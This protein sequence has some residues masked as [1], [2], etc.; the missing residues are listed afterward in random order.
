MV[1]EAIIIETTKVNDYLH[2]IDLKAYGIPRQLSVYL[3]EFNNA[4]ILFDCGSSLDSKKI[5]RY[6]NKKRIPL[7]SFKYLITSHHHFDHNGGQF[8][9][10][11]E[12]K[13]HNPNVKI[14]TNS[15]TKEL[16][17]N[18]ND[19]LNRAKRTYGNLTGTMKQ[20]EDEAF[21]I[22]EPSLKFNV[23][24]EPIDVFKIN[25]TD[26]KLVIYKTPGHTPDHVCPAF[27]RNGKLEFIFWGKAVGTIYHSSKLVTMPTSMPIYYNHEDYM[28]SLSNLKKLKAEKAGFG[29]F[30][31]I[32]GIDNVSTIMNEHEVFMKKF[33][34]KI[35]DIYAEKP[36]TKYVFEKVLPYL[37]PRTDLP[38]DSNS[39][40]KNIALG[41]VYG[42]MMDLGYRNE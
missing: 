32:D 2:H 31:V 28:N 10:Y 38:I 19:H 15:K 34:Q 25:D 39:I 17:N 11:D 23:N 41:I 14:L 29:H 12:L 40:F 3:A 22:I 5:I 33:R 21:K 35:I 4:T 6:C 26:V 16:L 20:I 13:K 9:L 8:I 27:I 18:F 37:T 1:N 30:G 42:M 36:E 24:I 7:S